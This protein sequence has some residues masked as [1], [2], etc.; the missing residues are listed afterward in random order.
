MRHP[1]LILICWLTL[2]AGWGTPCP[3]AALT[4]MAGDPHYAPRPEI[5]R[6]YFGYQYHLAAGLLD[7]VATTPADFKISSA[8]VELGLTMPIM[9]AA[10]R[11]ILAGGISYRGWQFFYENFD[12]RQ[13]YPDALH[14]IRYSVSL[15]RRPSPEHAWQ[16][17][18]SPGI[19]SDFEDID[20]DDFGFDAQF[21]H[22]WQKSD[23]AFGIGAAYLDDFG[24]PLPLLLLAYVRKGETSIDIL[25][26]LRAQ[27]KHSL[28]S[29]IA[30]GFLTEITGGRFHLGE[31]FKLTDN[32]TSLDG[33]VEYFLW[34]AEGKIDLELGGGLA[35]SLHGGLDIIRRFQIDDQD[36][37]EI[38]SLDLEP[39]P[40]V[41]ARISL[42]R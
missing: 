22:Y 4:A 33:R 31:D 9:F 41:G 3:A 5:Q 39:G 20:G 2:S 7:A 38:S 18:I 36:G 21:I 34:Q 27:I 8:V 24:K 23:G 19:V 30:L 26:P 6:V 40:Y 29:G 28:S 11:T 16:I 25:L 13:F 15:E 32:R 14:E 37:T 35:L 42:R 17:Q 1:G 10:G 12:P